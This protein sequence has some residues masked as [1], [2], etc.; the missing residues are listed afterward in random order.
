MICAASGPLA[1]PAHEAHSTHSAPGPWLLPGTGACGQTLTGTPIPGP[2]TAVPEL[3]PAGPCRAGH[4]GRG[5]RLAR[6]TCWVWHGRL[7]PRPPQ[8]PLT[9]QKSGFRCLFSRTAAR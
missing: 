5:G 2:L 4:G 1:L 9:L 3:L 6:V 7:A 8:N